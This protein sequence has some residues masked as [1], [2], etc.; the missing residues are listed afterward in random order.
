VSEALSVGA[1]S[2][3]FGGVR[4]VDSVSFAVADS[5]VHG[6]V[7]PN[8]SGKTTILNAVCGFVGSRGS[9]ALDGRRIDGLPSHRRMA[10]RLGRTFQNPRGGR[11]LTVRELLQIGEHLQG[12]QPWWLV[13]FAPLRADRQLA[14]SIE[15]GIELLGLVGLEQAILDE[16]LVHLPSGVLKMVDIVRALMGEPRVLL[17]DEPTSGMNDREIRTLHAALLELRRK[18]LTVLLVEH[19]LRFMFD[20]CTSATVLDAGH[21]VAD[22]TPAEIFEREEVI[23]AYIGDSRAA[24]SWIER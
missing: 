5:T 18:S 22:G 13:T 10:L 4:A 11:N 23:R 15:R 21:V 16:R 9:I 3:G 12:R 8:G 1:L 6:L 19:N 24:D 20:V 7:G 14:R 17:L 2:V